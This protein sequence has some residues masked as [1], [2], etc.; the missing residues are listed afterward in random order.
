MRRAG[1][2][3]YSRAKRLVAIE[4]A[5]PPPVGAM[6]PLGASD[7]RKPPELSLRGYLVREYLYW[8]RGLVLSVAEAIDPT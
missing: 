1:L 6:E 3:V 4:T 5:E 2:I 7:V 8:R